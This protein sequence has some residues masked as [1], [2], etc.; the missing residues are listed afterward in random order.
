MLKSG[1]EMASYALCFL[2]CD[3]I[4][5]SLWAMAMDQRG[6]GSAEMVKVRYRW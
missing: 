3:E 2:Q 4:S 5:Q 6:L 1:E